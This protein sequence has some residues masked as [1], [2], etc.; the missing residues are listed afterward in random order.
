MVSDSYKSRPVFISSN[1]VK[2]LFEARN[3]VDAFRYIVARED[4]EE[5]LHE[6]LKNAVSEK[7]QDFWSKLALEKETLTIE[8]LQ[9]IAFT[10]LHVDVNIVEN[11]ILDVEKFKKA[12]P[13]LTEGAEFITEPD[14]RY[15]VGAEVEKMSKS[16]FNVVNPDDIVT[17]YGAD[18]L[19]LYE[20]FLGPLEQAKPWNT[21]GIDGVYRFIRKFYRLFY[22]DDAAGVRQLIVT[23]EPPTPAE[24]KVLHRTI[25]KT[26]DDIETYSFNTSV[27]SFMICVNELAALGCHKRAV[28][29]ELVLLL[30]PYAPHIAEEL[31]AALGNE[32]GTVSKAEFPTFNPNFLI[33]DAFEYP[34]QINGKV[35]T[36]ISFAID[37]APIE[38]ER[39][40]L[41]DEIVQK[42]LDGK[43]P[44]KVVV[45]PKRIVNV[46]I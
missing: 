11:D 18:V 38:I 35:R 45:V 13:D 46:V 33:E 40:V 39:A 1:V 16:K 26:E 22:K 20:M 6:A 37:R 36:T 41:A 27:S 28:L 5:A 21:N 42:W 14:G 32:P 9:K 2:R 30:S 8:H 29:Q 17:K 4:F 19:R 10:P 3:N 34:I 23:D 43:L 25:K 24:L 44:K 7:G 31:W 12:R 15:I